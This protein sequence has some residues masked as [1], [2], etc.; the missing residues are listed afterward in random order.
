MASPSGQLYIQDAF[1]L[2]LASYYEPDPELRSR[3]VLVYSKDQE[4]RWGRMDVGSRSVVHMRN[5]THFATLPYESVASQ[6]G[7]H[8]FVTVHSN[9]SGW[10]DLQEDWT[11]EAFAAAHAN[12]RLVGSA[13]GGD[14]VLVRFL[15]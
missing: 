2:A 15:P 12:V 4:A 9:R 6:P 14:V 5:F 11:D 8:I 3:M 7:D 10:T 1:L 13:F